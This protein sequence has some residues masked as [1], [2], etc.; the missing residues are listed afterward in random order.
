MYSYQKLQDLEKAIYNKVAENRYEIAQYNLGICYI[1]GEGVEKETKAF[2]YFKK[3]AEKEYLN[4]QYKLGYRYY[5][6]I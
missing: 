4:A 6:G 3:S 2:E 5:N 1:I